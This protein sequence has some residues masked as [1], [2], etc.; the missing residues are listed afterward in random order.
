MHSKEQR[1]LQLKGG[2]TPSSFCSN[3]LNNQKYNILSFIPLVLINEFKYFFNLFF[4]I[5]ALS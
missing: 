1:L 2:T 4:L 5:I 3:K